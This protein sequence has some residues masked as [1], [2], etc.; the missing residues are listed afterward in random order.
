MEPVC[1]SRVIERG[2]IE[3]RGKGRE[4]RGRGESGASEK[5]RST[6]PTTQSRLFACPFLVVLHV[7]K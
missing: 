2:E 1:R 5:V 4:G 6:F 3:G 7:F